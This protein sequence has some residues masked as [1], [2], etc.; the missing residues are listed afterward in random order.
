[1]TYRLE[2]TPATY[3][4]WALR[5]QERKQRQE[6]SLFSRQVMVVAQTKAMTVVMMRD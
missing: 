4:R 2:V 1:M 6:P 3:R 5:G